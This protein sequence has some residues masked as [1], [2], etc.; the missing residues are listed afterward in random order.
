MNGKKLVAILVCIAFLV[1]IYSAGFVQAK[2][3]VSTLTKIEA[4]NA[5]LL[6]LGPAETKYAGFTGKG[7]VVVP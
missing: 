4:E 6:K 3:V 2:T 1:G 5:K 7:Y